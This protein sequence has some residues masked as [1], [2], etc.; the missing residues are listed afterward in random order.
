V[1]QATGAL[2]GKTVAYKNEL[3]FQHD[4][5][6]NDLPAWQRRGVG[7]LW[8]NYEKV[9]YNPIEQKEVITLRRRVTVDEDLP[10]K[11]EYG[12]YLRG[13]MQPGAAGE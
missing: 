10:M 1:G 4:I 2:K 7:L 6:F 12:A 9:G 11:D 13:L 8:E 5:N 3:L